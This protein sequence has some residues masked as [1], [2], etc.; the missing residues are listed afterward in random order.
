[1]ELLLRFALTYVFYRREKVSMTIAKFI[2][3]SGRYCYLIGYG[4]TH[5]IQNIQSKVNV[6]L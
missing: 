3:N 4:P 6:T 5:M 1:M 2:A